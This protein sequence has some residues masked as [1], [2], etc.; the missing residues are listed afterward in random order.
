[1]NNIESIFQ[2]LIPQEGSKQSGQSSA[3]VTERVISNQPSPKY[4]L[5]SEQ[6]SFA[7]N[8]SDSNFV[9]SPRNLRVGV[10]AI[11]SE[12]QS[13]ANESKSGITTNYY[14]SSSVSPVPARTFQ[15]SSSA[16]QSPEQNI[17]AFNTGGYNSSEG[18]RINTKTVTYAKKITQN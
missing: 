15:F 17:T 6:P 13:R 4:V 5:G 16:Y 11:G 1:M 7:A 3:V 2:A 8:V 9:G 12:T 14:N 10:S 18:N